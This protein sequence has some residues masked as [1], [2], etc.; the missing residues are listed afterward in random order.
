MNDSAS[1]LSGPGRCILGLA[2]LHHIHRPHDRQAYLQAALDA[3]VR[4]FDTAPLYGN[5]LAETE[6]GFALGAMRSQVTL[7]T[8]FGIPVRMYGERA[9]HLFLP[10]R[11][12]D[13]L[14]PGYRARQDGRDYTAAALIESVEGSL[15][16]L[17]TEHIDVLFVHEPTPG[18]TLSSDLLEA[19]QRL[20]ATG[21]IGAFGLAGEQAAALAAT[22][23]PQV[24]LIQAPIEH[25][26]QSP[27]AT[28]MR[29]R[30][31]FIHRA[32]AAAPVDRRGTFPSFVSSLLQDRPGV[33]LLLAT[34]SLDRLRALAPLFSR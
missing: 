33:D 23:P 4:H 32:Y 30:A 11:I 7:S 18:L 13:R 22:A 2:S 20:Q 29:Q 5:G 21:K 9:R 26:D 3:G 14:L 24:G 8:K 34:R 25:L 19:A 17:R 27:V 16:R 10:M 1:A 28:R 15:R 6:L 31:Y 12:V